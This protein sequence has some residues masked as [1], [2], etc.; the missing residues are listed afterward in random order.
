MDCYIYKAFTT[1]IYNPKSS[2]MATVKVI[3]K[4]HH[5]KKDGTYPVCIRITQ[6]NKSRYIYAGYSVKPDQFKEG[7]SDWIRRHPDAL[8]INST[9]EDIRAKILDKITRLRLDGKEIDINFL[10][11]DKEKEGPTLK[12]ILYSI[13]ENF[14]EG[15]EITQA[16]R[17]M[18]IF[19]QVQECL[20]NNPYLADLTISD[21]QKIANYFKKINKV[22]TAAR[23]LGYLRT[24]FDHAKRQYILGDNPFKAISIRQEPVD[25]CPL[26]KQQ[27]EEIERL[28]LTGFIDV[29]RDLFLFSYYSQGMR[30][31][32]C[33]TLKRDQITATH[34]KYRMNKGLHIRELEVHPKMKRIIDKYY[35]RDSPYLFPVLKKEVKT[36]EELHYAKE[37]ANVMVNTALK[38]IALLAGIDQKVSFHIAKHA[39]AQMVKR[40]GVDPWIVK[41]SLGH[42][43]FRTTEAYLKSLDDD[44]I[45][46]AV[47]GL[48]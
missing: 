41:D 31:E 27:L 36:K 14:R 34:V 47:T 4:D 16:N 5:K 12:E 18:S 2:K 37:E 38:R 10:A 39:Y 33:I 43:T 30:F 42:T 15:G 3:L 19:R 35:N 28:H 48:Y 9:I 8:F 13:S 6:G 45:N 40:A 17:Q 25:R 21:A 1:H 29:A 7:Q 44:Q 24:A 23:K 32:K 11:S 46:K 22:N 26:S 20:G